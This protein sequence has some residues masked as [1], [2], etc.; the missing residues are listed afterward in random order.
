MLAYGRFLGTQARV[1]SKIHKKELGRHHLHIG[2]SIYTLFGLGLRH[3]GLPGRPGVWAGL[4]G[5][6]GQAFRPACG[7]RWAARCTLLT[8]WASFQSLA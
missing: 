1:W 5:H 7:E 2:G 3:T 4:T 6:P 8:L